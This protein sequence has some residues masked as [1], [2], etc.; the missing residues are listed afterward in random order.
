MDARNLQQST[1]GTSGDHEVGSDDE[2]EQP[3]AAVRDAE[4]D[5]TAPQPIK[6]AC[7]ECRSQK[8]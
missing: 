8:V 3:S 4:N 7:N 5:G 6:R 1:R 2:E